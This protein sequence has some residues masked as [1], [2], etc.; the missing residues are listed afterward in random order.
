MNTK[1]VELIGELLY[2][3]GNDL[4]NIQNLQ[5]NNEIV[6]WLSNQIRNLIFELEALKADFE[7]GLTLAECGFFSE[8]DFAER[9]DDYTVQIN[10][11]K[12]TLINLKGIS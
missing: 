9:L 4:T 6:G 1:Q 7:C 2:L 10:N 8:Q 11:L 5:N 12:A 3:L